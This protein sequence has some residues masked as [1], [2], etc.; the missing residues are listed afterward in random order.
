M[1]IAGERVPSS[2]GVTPPIQLTL[3][4]VTLFVDTIRIRHP[5]S[6]HQMAG[7]HRQSPLIQSHLLIV[8][9]NWGTRGVTIIRIDCTL[10]IRVEVP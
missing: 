7:T 4:I 6:G 10:L 9:H 3:L 2:S 8:P 5:I 1:Q